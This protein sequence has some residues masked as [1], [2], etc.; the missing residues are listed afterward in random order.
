VHG[1]TVLRSEEAESVQLTKPAIPRLPADHT[2]DALS[3][4][5]DEWGCC[6]IERAADASVMDAIAQDLAPH[7]ARSERGSSDFA[8][9]GTRRTGFVLNRSPSFR[10]IAMHPSV[11]AAGEHVLSGAASW[12]LSSVGFFELFS[13]APKQLLHRD[14]WK[15]GVQDLPEVDCNA[16]WAVTDF[17]AENGATE[18][19]PGSHRWEDDRMAADDESVPAEMPKGSV[20]LYTGQTH[21]G[22]GANRSA[23]VRVGLSV[24]HSAGWLVQT[25]FLMVE[26]PPEEIVDWPDDLIRFLGYQRRGPAVGKIGDH[27]DPFVLIEKARAL[28]HPESETA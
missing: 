28:K 17:T 11:L 22:G 21:H 10:R 26:C 1:D 15:Y 12:N 13:G 23:E 4:A 2:H 7:A 16:M 3:A 24:Q 25:E 6:V 19:V 5:L 14:I 27:D 20:L 9:S 8:G 18:L